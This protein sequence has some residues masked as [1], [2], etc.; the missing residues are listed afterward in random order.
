MG[1]SEPELHKIE[2]VVNELKHC[3]CT[4]NKSQHALMLFNG[5]QFRHTNE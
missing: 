5:N 4:S 1:R 3:L 2:R